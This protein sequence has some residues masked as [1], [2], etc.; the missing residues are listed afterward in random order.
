MSVSIKTIEKGYSEAKE[1]Y[2]AWGVDTDLVIN[3][4]SE[5]SVS[6]HCWQCDDVNGFE[7][8]TEQLTGG[9]QATGNYPGRARNIAELTQD[10]DKA[11]TLIPGKKRLNLHAIYLDNQGKRVERNKLETGHFKY[12]VDWAKNKKIGLDFNPSL[13]SHP[14]SSDGFTLSHHDKAIRDFWIEHS[15][16][17]RKIGEYFGKELGTPAVTNVWIPDGYKDTP[18]DKFAP[19]QRLKEALDEIFKE[20][21]SPKYNLDAIEGKLFGLGSESYVVGSHDFYLGYALKNNKLLC[22]D[23]GHFHPTEVISDKISAVLNFMDSILIHVSRPVRWDSD[24][25][26]VLN[27]ELQAIMSELVRGN[28]LER[29]HIALDYFDAGINRV[30]AM[31]IGARNVQKALLLAMLEPTGQLKDLELSGDYTSRLALIE[32]FKTYPFGA[33]WDYYCLSQNVPVRQ[34]WLNEVKDYEKKVQLHRI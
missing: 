17:C 3:K 30:A 9:I 8:S 19:R 34:L 26:V 21:I 11:M 6:L 13:F 10:L 16:A 14:L 7:G 33:I 23:A 27:D 15:K 28:F 12:W 22:M 18:I 29:A 2:A 32:E 1:Q 4:L 24:H 25:V 31:A 20:E 5:V